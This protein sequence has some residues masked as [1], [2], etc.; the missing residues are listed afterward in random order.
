[1]DGLEDHNRRLKA[2][3]DEFSRVNQD[4]NNLKARL[5]Q[6]NFELQRQLQDLDSN[7]GIL[8]KAKA[9]LQIQ[10]DDTKNRLDEETRVCI[11]QR[12]INTVCIMFN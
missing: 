6:E 12:I 10:L 4:L 8:S 2:Q 7:N 1:V 3:N 11:K 5:T 9:Q